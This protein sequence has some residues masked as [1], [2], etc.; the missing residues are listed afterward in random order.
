MKTNPP[1]SYYYADLTYTGM[2][3]VA[4]GAIQH[5]EGNFND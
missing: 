5:F 3:E 4:N 2:F 1:T